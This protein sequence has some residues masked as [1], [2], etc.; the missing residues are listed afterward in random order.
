MI[1]IYLILVSFVVKI[2]SGGGGGGCDATCGVCCGCGGACA[3]LLLKFCGRNG[4]YVPLYKL[5][6]KKYYYRFMIPP[7]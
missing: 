2:I 6:R 5:I 1:L 3:C 4:F 7:P